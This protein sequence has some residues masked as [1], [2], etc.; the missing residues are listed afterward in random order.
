[1]FGPEKYI[2]GYLSRPLFIADILAFGCAVKIYIY[3]SQFDYLRTF[4]PDKIN[5][6]RI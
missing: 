2:P 4:Y 3:C 1:M 5:W 6:I